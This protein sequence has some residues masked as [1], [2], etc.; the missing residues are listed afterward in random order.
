M[1]SLSASF[2]MIED[3]LCFASFAFHSKVYLPPSSL[4]G[5]FFL[6]RLYHDLFPNHLFGRALSLIHPI[7]S[8]ASAVFTAD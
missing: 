7:A 2:L 8:I 3:T 4:V 6:I 1:P 5:S